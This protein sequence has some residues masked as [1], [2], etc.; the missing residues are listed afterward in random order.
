M[1]CDSPRGARSSTDDSALGSQS[2]E[3][4]LNETQ[5]L[6]SFRND[7]TECRV[8]DDRERHI[9]VN[10]DAGSEDLRSAASGQQERQGHPDF[11]RN[12]PI[13][14][15]SAPRADP[16]LGQGQQQHNTND[17]VPGTAV[18]IALNPGKLSRFDRAIFIGRLNLKT[19]DGY[20]QA[21]EIKFEPRITANAS[22]LQQV[23]NIILMEFTRVTATRTTILQNANASPANRN[24]Q[25][26]NMEEEGYEPLYVTEA[27]TITVGA[28]G[29]K[30]CEPDNF[31]PREEYFVQKRTA[32]SQFQILASLMA[33]SAPK[34]TLTYMRGGGFAQDMI[35]ITV[36]LRP[37]DFGSGISGCKRWQYEVLESYQS[38]LQCSATH[39]PQHRADITSNFTTGDDDIPDCLLA[40]VKTEF[41]L[42]KRKWN[43]GRSLG[44]IAS[45]QRSSIRHISLRLEARIKRGDPEDYFALPGSNKRGG[46]INFDVEFQEREIGRSLYGTTQTGPEPEGLTEA[47]FIV[48]IGS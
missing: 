48:K 38:N 43:F 25:Q 5:S 39:P 16:Y 14:T 36:G 41:R 9:E 29:G 42:K 13:R 32:S 3:L 35:P 33:S 10:N 11:S 28:S 12:Q 34:G 23:T 20:Q 19:C 8:S 15:P 4:Q 6:Q 47:N 18:G 30:P 46:S 7:N 21:L 27:V 31:E 45:W 26:V 2:D 24:S 40:R 37:K 22:D 17:Q 1:R 44:P